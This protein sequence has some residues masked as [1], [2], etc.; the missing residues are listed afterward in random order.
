MPRK[1]TKKTQYVPTIASNTI[2]PKKFGEGGKTRR[3][4]RLVRKSLG[5]DKAKRGTIAASEY[6]AGQ[7]N[8]ASGKA[9]ET[10][11]AK[12][13][14]IAEAVQRSADEGKSRRAARITKLAYGESKKEKQESSGNR[15]SG[16]GQKVRDVINRSS[17]SRGGRG[18]GSGRVRTRPTNAQQNA[19]DFN[20]MKTKGRKKASRKSG[21]SSGAA[22]CK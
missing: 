17:A 6:K 14:K 5:E 9:D 11:K 21:C 10:S 13:V 4:T 15:R 20:K 3:L 16:L 1:I 22:W 19:V 7:A 12:D 2:T 8:R 18:R